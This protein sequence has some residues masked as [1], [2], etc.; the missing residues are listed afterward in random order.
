MSPSFTAQTHPWMRGRWQLADA[1]LPALREPLCTRCALSKTGRAQ[2]A[3]PAASAARG[4]YAA[5]IVSSWA[6]R[7]LLPLLQV[8][9]GDVLHPRAVDEHVAAAE[10]PQEDAIHIVELLEPCCFSQ[11]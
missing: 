1:A 10:A 3:S 8:E 11:R 2:A 9:T 4:G 7:P 5:M 6:I